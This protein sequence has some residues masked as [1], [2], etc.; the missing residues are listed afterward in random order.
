MTDATTIESKPKVPNVT[1]EVVGGTF[2]DGSTSMGFDYP[3]LLSPEEL[4][5]YEAWARQQS[6][7]GGT[8]AGKPVLDETL[9]NMEF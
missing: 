9:G 4:A 1:L 5:A 3:E 6:A 8:G 2:D 7:A